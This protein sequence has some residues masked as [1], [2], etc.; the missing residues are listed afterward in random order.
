M[1]G[2]AISTPEDGRRVVESGRTSIRHARQTLALSETGNRYQANASEESAKIA[3]RLVRLTTACRG[4]GVGLC[5]VYLR[6]VMDLGWNRKWVYRIYREL[7]LNLRIKPR[8]CIV[9]DR[10]D[11]LLVPDTINQ[12]WSMDF[13]QHRLS[14]RHTFLLFTVLHDFNREALEIEVDLLLPSVR[15]IQALEQMIEWRGKP[16]AIRC[17]HGPECISATLLT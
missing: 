13:T 15:V 4:R 12:V 1:N 6:N 3:C 14:D 16:R 2:E 9:R 8:K 7:E 17:A 10:P 5:F 11:P